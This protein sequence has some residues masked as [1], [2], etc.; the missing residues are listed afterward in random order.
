MPFPI[1][2]HDLGAISSMMKDLF[3]EEGASFVAMM[4]HKA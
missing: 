4:A 1:A 2:A 3:F